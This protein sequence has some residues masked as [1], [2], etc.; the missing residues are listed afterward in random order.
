[1]KV[2]V[3]HIYVAHEFVLSVFVNIFEH[4]GQNMKNVAQMYLCCHML[5]HILWEIF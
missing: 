1:M 3:E 2:F 4:F 5:A